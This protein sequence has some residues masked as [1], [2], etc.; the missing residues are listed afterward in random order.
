M[1]SFKYKMI[2]CLVLLIFCAFVYILKAP[3]IIKSVFDIECPGCGLTRAYTSLFF[4][5]IKKAFEYNAMFWALPIIFLLY[6]FGDI[7][8]KYKIVFDVILNL[9]C[10]GFLLLWL[11]RILHYNM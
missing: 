3:C 4:L 6:L 5:D 2:E 11:N 9:L 10:L 8:G 7:S 1:K